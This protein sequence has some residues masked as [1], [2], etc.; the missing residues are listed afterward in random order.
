MKNE[1]DFSKG[2]RGALDPIPAGKTRITI[3]IDDDILDWFRNEV[4]SIGGGNYQ[5]L[6]NQALREYVLRRQEPLEE[7]LRRVVRE[8]LHSMAG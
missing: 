3:R 5:T 1:Y 4:D 7:I 8:E 6:M 2:K